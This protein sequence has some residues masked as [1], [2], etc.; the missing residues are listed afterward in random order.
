MPH[1]RSR[2]Q[3]MA[4]GKIEAHITKPKPEIYPSIT[5]QKIC[6]F[7]FFVACPKSLKVPKLQEHFSAIQY[8]IE[9][10]VS[11]SILILIS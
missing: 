2:D 10:N 5:S 9:I 1:V 3:A 4:A 6:L 7:Q 8:I 11:K